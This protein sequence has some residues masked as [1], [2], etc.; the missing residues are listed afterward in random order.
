MSN[1]CDD[2]LHERELRE[3][4]ETGQQ[5]VHEAEHVA[6]KVA[7]E[8][9]N[10]RLGHMNEFRIQITDERAVYVRRDYVDAVNSSIDTRLRGLERSKSFMIGYVTA[11]VAVATLIMYFVS[12]K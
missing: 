7:L 6:L 2:V 10:D 8:S 11:I 1:E 3:Q 9:V 12:K 5:R 4:W